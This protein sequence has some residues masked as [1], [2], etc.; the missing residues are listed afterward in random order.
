MSKRQHILNITKRTFRDRVKYRSHQINQR[1]APESESEEESYTS[2]IQQPEQ[3]FCPPNPST[4]ANA[5]GPSTVFEL[6]H[7]NL[8]HEYNDDHTEY[9]ND[10]TSDE[11]EDVQKED[12]ASFLKSLYKDHNIP[13][14]ALTKLLKFLKRNGFPE[15]PNDSRTLLRTPKNSNIVPM[16]PGS[17]SHIGLKKG[18]DFYIQNCSISPTHLTIDVNIDGVPISRSSQSHFWLILAKIFSS[19]T[20]PVVV[21]VGVYHGYKKPNP[22]NNFLQQFI[23][24][25]KNL[26]S[27]EYN[28]VQIPVEIRCIIC[29]APARNYCLG[30]KSFCGYY[31]CGRCTQEGE[32]RN[33]R[34][35]FP[36]LDAPKRTN[37]SFRSQSCH[38][39]HLY[40]SVFLELDIDLVKQFPLDYLHTL[41]LGVVKKILSAFV[42]GDA[43][44]SVKL[45]A[46][47]IEQISKRLELISQHQP[48]EFQR[49]CRPLKDLSYFKGSEFR[50]LILYILPVATKDIISHDV[51]EHLLTL[52][53]A[54]LILA[55]PVLCISHLDVAQKLLEH[56]VS[57]FGNIYGD[58][59]VIYNVHSLVHIVDDV[60]LYGNL[61]SYSAFP[62]ESYMYKIKKMLRKNNQCLAQ[63]CN[64]IEEIYKIDIKIENNLTSEVVLKKKVKISD[65]NC[66]YNE[67]VF[68]HF[69]INNKIRNQ[70]FLTH[71]GNVYKFE[72]AKK[73]RNENIIFALKV[74]NK[75]EFFSLPISSIHFNIFLSDGKV[76]G[77]VCAIQINEVKNKIFAMPLNN[78]IVFAPFRHTD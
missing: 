21:V 28:S 51:Y 54:V 17:Y 59:H 42:K 41:C 23:D 3:T 24:D 49:K 7:D 5:P 52:H 1:I 61:D 36:Q 6:P 56:F 53:V 50:S 12:A 2:P 33:N 72:Y 66:R 45:Q 9:L 69:T 73:N 48:V 22:F 67:V 8:H 19:S 65:F 68:P 10:L 30:T 43:K 29:D 13:H 75:K 71:D 78:N 26:H 39:H 62:F 34:M 20:P 70:W 15:L 32:R 77:T 4:Q 63:V 31:G 11:D 44:M 35:T 27:Y 16:N 14:E 18:L 25:A 58:E 74:I 40:D 47:D 37:E 60:K 38:D 46:Y 76:S 55:D 64:R 57:S